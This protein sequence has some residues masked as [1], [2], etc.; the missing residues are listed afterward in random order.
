MVRGEKSVKMHGK[1]VPIRAQIK[2]LDNISAHADYEDILKWFSNFS[3][4]PKKIFITH[5]E[6]K[7]ALSLKQKIEEKL[8]WHAVIPS[9]LQCFTLF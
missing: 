4:A 8:K 3:Q 6:M 9:Y 1:M 2:V 7:A 5:G